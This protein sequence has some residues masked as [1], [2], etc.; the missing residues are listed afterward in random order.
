MTELSV[1]DST[2]A[3]PPRT[4]QWLRRLSV[5]S[6]V[7]I[8]AWAPFPLG[9]AV[10]WGNGELSLMLMIAMLL[11]LAATMA[12]SVAPVVARRDVVVPFVLLLLVLGYALVQIVPIGASVWAHPIWT[13]TSEGLH[14]PI[15]GTI[16]ID[17]WRSFVALTRLALPVGAG[18]LTYS[19]AARRETAS[20]LFDAALIIGVLYAVY[21]FVMLLTGKTQA[22]LVYGM[23]FDSQFLSGPFMLHNSFATYIGMTALG[24]TMRLIYAADGFVLRTRGVRWLAVTLIQF[25]FGRGVGFVLAALIAPAAV[26]ASA[27]RGGFAA[28]VCGLLAMMIIGVVSLRR[29]RVALWPV[30]GVILPIAAIFVFI[31]FNG[32]QLGDRLNEF[33]VGG[34]NEATRPVLWAAAERMI[35]DA[36][37]TGLGLGTFQDAYPLYAVQALPFVMD[38]T[39]SDYLELAAGLGLPAAIVLWVGL[40]WFA[41]VCAIGALRRRRDR[42]FV[43][44]A[45][46]A[47]VLVAVHSAVDFSLQ[48]PAVALQYA[49]LL[50]I[51]VAQAARTRLH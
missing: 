51:G 46:G 40:A 12:G 13:M 21:A 5:G 16:S 28:M 38:K 19:L 10:S 20:F 37:W 29:R 50:G 25:V 41:V 6:L 34:D 30:V 17:P 7:L 3:T 9:S 45:L 8:L 27:S 2:G 36:P 11:W 49:V 35:A 44:T 18:V 24:A 1:L 31:V 43:L 15:A 47:S 14:R 4:A 32:N 23:K 22:G 26:V 42:Q 39:H 48:I 33:L